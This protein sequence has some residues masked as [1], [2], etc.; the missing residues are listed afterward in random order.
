MNSWYENYS[1][2]SSCGKFNPIVR[3]KCEYCDSLVRHKSRYFKKN[4]FKE[5][6]RYAIA[7]IPTAF[8]VCSSLYNTVYI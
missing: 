1:Y 5:I 7:L 4:R 3:I 6:K 2:C 8:I